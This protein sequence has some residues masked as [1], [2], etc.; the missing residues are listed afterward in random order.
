M[1]MHNQGKKNQIAT[2]EGGGW[3]CEKKKRTKEQNKGR[4]GRVG[5]PLLIAEANEQE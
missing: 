4:R 3:L 2:S 1:M 5:V